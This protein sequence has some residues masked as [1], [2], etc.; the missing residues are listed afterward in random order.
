MV[1]RTITAVAALAALGSAESFS[2]DTPEELVTTAK[3]LAFDLMTLYNGNETGET[4]GILPGPPPAGDYYWW[5][6]AGFFATFLDYW[7]VTGDDSYND[8]VV[9]GLVHQRGPGDNYMPPNITATLGNDDQC[10]WALASMIAAENELPE[11]GNGE[12]SWLKVAENVFDTMAWRDDV[13]SGENGT[14][15]GGLRWQVA[16]FNAGYDF[17]N[18]KFMSIGS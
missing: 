16:M 17:K 8:V 10:G 5:E 1:A 18:S 2:I 9:Q 3:T 4:P 11:P 12:A 6:A 15:G 7:H 14:C 13:E